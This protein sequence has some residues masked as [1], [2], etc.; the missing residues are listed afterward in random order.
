MRNL[1]INKKHLN[2]ILI[3]A[4]YVIL[5][6]AMYKVLKRDFIWNGDD[7][8]YQFQRIMGVGHNFTDG[9]LTSNISSSNF[10]RIGYGVNLFYPWLTLIPFQ[11][12]Y[13]LNGNW[14][15]TYYL[16]LLFFFLISFLISHY[17]MKQFS[18]SSKLAVLFAIIY[19]FSTYRLIEMFSRA[20]LAEYV[21]SIF[22]PLCF[23]GLYQVFFGDSKK[24]KPLAI[25]LSLVIFSHVLTTF[26]T[27]MMFVL[28]LVV[29]GYKIKFTK[30]RLLC[31]V[32]ATI[33]TVLA[34]LIFTF[35]FLSEELY[36]KY[37]LPDPTKLQGLKLSDLILFSLDNTSY[38]A[39]EG[40]VYNIGLLLIL[41]ILFGAIL[42]KKFNSKIRAVYIIFV[43]STMLATN[44][45][46]WKL[47]QNTPVQAI[48]F[49]FRFLLFATLF[50]SVVMA[51]ELSFA[52]EFVFEN[53][54]VF[55][56]LITAIV[57][58]GLWYSSIQ[59]AYPNTLLSRSQL[60]IDNNT[61]SSNRVPDPFPGQYLPKRAAD[62]LNQINNHM[63]KVNGRKFVQIPEEEHN[64]NSFTLEGIKKG[65]VIDLPYIRYKYTQASIYGRKVPISF[66]KRRTVQLVAKHNY[67]NLRINLSY[68]S[69]NLFTLVTSLSVLMWIHLLFSRPIAFVLDKLKRKDEPDIEVVS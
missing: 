57:A 60:V 34:T 12:I 19:N 39:I 38:R 68:G 5:S 28:I 15:N 51:K 65:D 53:H 37:V 59:N 55:M 7:V 44:I 58:G 6:L 69:R 17:A 36:Q 56:S 66:S 62:N 67:A 50:G 63:V 11:I 16:G 31:L 9:L 54:F 13:N 64:G 4:L 20:S 41:A 49:P 48:Q 18:K 22:L 10:G 21:A 32:K 52:F 29:F 2:A 8:Y 47:L 23:L 3:F 35:S 14:I 27:I 45:F 24:W 30:S 40:N 26:M 1:K 42:Y 61:V 43:I 33:S 46:P 25:G